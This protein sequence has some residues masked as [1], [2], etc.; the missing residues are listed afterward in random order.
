MN[1]LWNFQTF[2]VQ[3]QGLNAFFGKIWQNL[4]KSVKISE[5][6]YICQTIGDSFG[7]LSQN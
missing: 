1:I 4:A 7:I 5:K 2:L 6:G 3:I